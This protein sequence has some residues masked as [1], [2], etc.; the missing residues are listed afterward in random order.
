MMNDI[1]LIIFVNKAKEGLTTNSLC[2][3]IRV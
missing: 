3:F 2:V 1:S